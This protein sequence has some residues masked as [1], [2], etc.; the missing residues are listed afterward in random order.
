MS[1]TCTIDYSQLDL[2]PLRE[3]LLSRLVKTPTGCWEYG[4]SRT[5]RGYGSITFHR[6]PLLT[7]RI[8]Y[9]LFKSPIPFG[10]FVL[11]TCDNPC[12]CNPDHLYLGQAADNSRDMVEHERSA[13][14]DRNGLRLHP[15]SIIFGKRPTNARLTDERVAAVFELRAKGWQMWRIGQQIGIPR[16]MVG[17]ILSGKI[18][19]TFPAM[20]QLQYKKKTPVLKA[21]TVWSRKTGNSVLV[22]ATTDGKARDQGAKELSERFIGTG[23]K[24]SPEC[25]V[26]P[27]AHKALAELKA[28]GV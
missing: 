9:Q 23:L 5:R 11:H 6:R 14:G 4:P 16:R 7:H 2:E 8:A 28:R 22:Y 3:K 18:Y 26:Y 17:A 15:G 19:T 10:M 21:W 20:K 13:K 24:R 1:R 12:C 27:E 25:D